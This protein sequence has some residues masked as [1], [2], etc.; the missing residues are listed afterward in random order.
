MG[1]M[2]IRRDRQQKPERRTQD[3]EEDRV[4]YGSKELGCDELLLLGHYRN[5]CAHPPLRPHSHGNVFE[6]CLLALG[7][8]IFE[9]DGQS[10]QLVGGDVFVAKP[11]EVHGTGDHPSAR[12]SLYWLQIKYPEAKTSYLGLSP[13][14]AADLAERINDLPRHFHIGTTLAQ[15]F[16]QALWL[17]SLPPSTLRAMDL[18][19]RLVRLLIDIVAAGSIKT[20]V[21]LSA[22]IRKAI[23]HI[24]IHL[25][26]S[27]R[28]QAIAD[29]AGI[30]LP[31]LKTRFKEE[32]GMPP[33]EYITRTRIEKAKHELTNTK[34]PI[35]ELAFVLGFCSSQHFARVFKRF[36]GQTPSSCRRLQHTASPAPATLGAGPSF[37]PVAN[38]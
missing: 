38:S 20:E 23:S 15:T 7:M 13:L 31:H 28:L 6:I 18:R 3:I 35:T 24:Q 19:N 22:H 21:I 33:G 17:A 30:S 36:T 26:E 12:G 8:Q 32:V 16:E 2:G 9:A 4:V 5:I 34:C 10:Y 25:G 37:H 11:N 14:E 27:M 1:L 29:A